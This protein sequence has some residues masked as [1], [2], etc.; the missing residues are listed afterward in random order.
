MRRSSIRL[1]RQSLLLTLR[2]LF[3]LLCVYAVLLPCSC[4]DSDPEVVSVTGTV[5]FDFADEE[6]APATRLAFFMQTESAVQRADSVEAVHRETGMRWHVD[7]P[8]LIS[9]SDR[10]WVGYTN[11]QPA[12]GG[13]I[14]NGGYDCFYTDAAGNETSSRFTVR[15]P[16]ALLTA[17]VASARERMTVPFSEYIALYGDDGALMFFNKRRSSWLTNDDI[18]ADYRSA[19]T[20]RTCLVADNNSVICL[21]P[22]EMLREPAVNEERDDA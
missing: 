9:G 3:P 18:A 10:Q 4:A 13:K 5:V 22:A 8:R 6:R 17:T 15:Y 2:S 1:Q 16:E 20:L 19:L 11:L 14:L 21:L 12:G 7:E